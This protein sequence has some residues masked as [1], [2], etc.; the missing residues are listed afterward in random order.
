MLNELEALTKQLNNMVGEDERKEA[1]IKWI[2]HMHNT[3]QQNL[4]REMIWPLIKHWASLH[5]QNWYD[6]R[7]KATVKLSA[8]IINM[9]EKQKE[10]DIHPDFFPFI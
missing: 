8:A 9:V 10:K 6:D 5:E 3:L 2:S 1:V 4:M 7:N